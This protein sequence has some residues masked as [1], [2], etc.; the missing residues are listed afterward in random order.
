MMRAI[1]LAIACMALLATS[2][3]E[4]RAEIIFDNGAHSGSQIGRF[5]SGSF[6]IYEDFT[7]GTGAT[8]TGFNW[9]QHDRPL[10]YSSTTLSVFDGLPSGGNLVFSSDIVASRTPNGTPVFLESYVGFDYQISGL[11][12]TLS[13]GTYFFGLRNNVTGG[14]TIWDETVGTGQT[15]AGRYQTSSPPHPGKLYAPEDSAFQVNGIMSAVP[16]PSSLALLGIGAC[17]AGLGAIGRR[18]REK[19]QETIA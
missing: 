14:A 16:E 9:T 3:G 10:V 1:Q 11:S 13:P 18:R 8:I 2:A 5:N 7:L 4:V 15:I 12:L 6:T 19:P 17:V